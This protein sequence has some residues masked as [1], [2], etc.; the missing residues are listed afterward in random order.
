MGWRESL[1]EASFDGI[2]FK[3]DTAEFVGG[4]NISTKDIPKKEKATKGNSDIDKVFPKLGKSRESKTDETSLKPK[5]FNVI[6]YF[7]GEN[8]LSERNAILNRFNQGGA[9]ELI[10][11][12]LGKVKCFIQDFTAT[13][14]NQEGGFE[15]ISCVFISRPDEQ[16]VISSVDTETAL[17]GGVLDS[18]LSIGDSFGYKVLGVADY[19]F[20]E[21][22]NIAEKLSGSVFDLV[23]LGSAN[24]KV[25]D[26][27]LKIRSF[28]ADVATI[29]R[30]PTRYYE[31]ITEL[32]GGL[33]GIFDKPASAWEAQKKLF[34]SFGSDFK[35]VNQT[36]PNRVAQANNQDSVEFTVK[37]LSAVEMA[38]AGAGV[39][40]VSVE[41]SDLIKDQT[42]EALDSIALDVADSQQRQ[43]LYFAIVDVKDKFINQVEQASENLPQSRDI[44][45]QELEPSVVVAYDLYADEE[46]S[47]EIVERNGVIHP[48]FCD[49][50]LNVLSF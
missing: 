8:Y 29:I 32:V 44:S 48:L 2:R 10:L 13:F 37:A 9:G 47:G 20:D 11:P 28:E 5:V 49:R 16:Q 14:N 43:E 4:W 38:N 36:T 19:V 1:R 3:V 12:T 40:F 31:E 50:N 18:I 41:Q 33:S 22:E 23:G 21:A 25:S 45:T 35:P 24:D 7:V 39:D 34:D 42:I 27:M 46:R 15:T 26:Y 17:S 30:T 6:M